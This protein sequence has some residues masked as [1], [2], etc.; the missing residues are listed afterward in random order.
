MKTGPA[1]ACALLL[2][3]AGAASAATEAAGEIRDKPALQAARE[4]YW[5]CASMEVPS[6]L[7]S[8][9]EIRQAA[10]EAAT[11]CEREQLALAGHF[12]LQHPGSREVS[13]YMEQAR[14][15]LVEELTRRMGELESL[16]QQR[17][18]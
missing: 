2:L 8:P 15:Q 11:R 18:E 17:G 12:A 16:Y 9:A 6:R 5:L 13:R 10:N 14:R 1:A 3:L 4:A 7:S